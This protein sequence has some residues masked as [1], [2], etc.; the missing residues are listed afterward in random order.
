MQTIELWNLINAI[1]LINL[2]LNQCCSYELN[3]GII[4]EIELVSSG[5]D[6]TFEPYR[7][8]SAF[9]ITSFNYSTSS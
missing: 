4:A 9:C 3:L 7:A 2:L 1:F 8:Q 6:W 5:T